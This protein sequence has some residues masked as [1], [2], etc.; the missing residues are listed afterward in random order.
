MCVMSFTG[1]WDCPEGLEAQTTL[2]AADGASSAFGPFLLYN[3]GDAVMLY[4]QAVQ[5]KLCNYVSLCPGVCHYADAS[6][7]AVAVQHERSTFNQ[8]QTFHYLGMTG[9]AAFNLS[10]ILPDCAR[11][12]SHSTYHISNIVL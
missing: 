3:A 10:E 11:G 1:D 6:Q 8:V 4:D 5:C 7:H 9:P 12:L 2:P